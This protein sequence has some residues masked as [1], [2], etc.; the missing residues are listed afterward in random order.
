[1]LLFSYAQR[2]RASNCKSWEGNVEM[3]RHA[4]NECLMQRA[5]LDIAV[6]PGRAATLEYPHAQRP[7]SLLEII[8]YVVEMSHDQ[9]IRSLPKPSL[10]PIPAI[11]SQHLCN[12]CIQAIHCVPAQIRKVVIS[13]QF[14]LLGTSSTG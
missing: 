11:S 7:P 9:T 13:T 12:I 5:A 3:G 6:S 4:T 10:N 8:S 14:P 2:R 1:M